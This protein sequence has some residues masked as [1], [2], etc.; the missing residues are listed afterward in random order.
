MPRVRDG[1]REDGSRMG[2][3]TSSAAEDIYLF[4]VKITPFLAP[5]VTVCLGKLEHNLLS[6]LI[7]IA[8]SLSLFSTK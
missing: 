6:S 1:D 7:G 3:V 5:T 2:A 4:N 8:L